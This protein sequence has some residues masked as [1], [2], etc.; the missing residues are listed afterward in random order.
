[1]CLL[2]YKV[3]RIVI[4]R[5]HNRT[6]C[7]LQFRDQGSKDC[8]SESTACQICADEAGGYVPPQNPILSPKKLALWLFVL[9][10]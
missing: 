6:R 8:S 10:H 7:W 5:N 1:M 4:P 2:D 9:S 3:A